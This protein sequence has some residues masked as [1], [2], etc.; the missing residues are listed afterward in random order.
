M[1]KI[2]TH[3]ADN[4]LTGKSKWWGQPDMPENLDYPEVTIVDD[5]GETYE[6]PLTFVCQIRCADIA[7]LDPE[8][9]GKKPTRWEN[10]CK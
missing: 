8:A 1:I 10:C 3:P 9:D 5:D 2:E 6:D 7:A 4:P